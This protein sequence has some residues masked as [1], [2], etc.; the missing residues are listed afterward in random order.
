MDGMPLGSIVNLSQVRV[1]VDLVP[2]F[3]DKADE[4]LA[5]ENCFTYS[6]KFWLN[7]YFNKEIFYVL[8][9]IP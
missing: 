9:V 4:H 6:T 2:H 1:L 5:K 3:R 8:D 7:K